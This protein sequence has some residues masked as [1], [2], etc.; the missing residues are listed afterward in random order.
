MTL[1]GDPLHCYQENMVS[2]LASKEFAFWLRKDVR[3]KWLL[4]KAGWEGRR[5]LTNLSQKW[6]A[7]V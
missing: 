5:A 6:V 1:T 2:I 7:A 3:M 4:S